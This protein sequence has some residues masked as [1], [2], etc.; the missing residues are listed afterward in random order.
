MLVSEPRLGVELRPL[1]VPVIAHNS[2]AVG[3]PERFQ[4]V[5]VR[6]LANPTQFVPMGSDQLAPQCRVVGAGLALP[7]RV[8]SV[9]RYTPAIHV[10]S[11]HGVCFDAVGPVARQR[12][13]RGEI[14]LRNG[15]E[16]DARQ[17]DQNEHNGR[18]QSAPGAK[19]RE[20]S[21]RVVSVTFVFLP[22][23]GQRFSFS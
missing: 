20:K 23:T 22:E 3:I 15:N 7:V 12:C 9:N 6:R 18:A 4:V 1:S 5:P 16:R 21:G 13:V 11:H 2:T 19:T 10:C 17:Q 14:L 8:R